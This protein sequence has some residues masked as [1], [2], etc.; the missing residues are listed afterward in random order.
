M[1]AA[2]PARKTESFL[3]RQIL[4]TQ[5][6]FKLKIRTMGCLET[7]STNTINKLAK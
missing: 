2:R 4:D 5:T 6:S 7:I 3:I 1:A